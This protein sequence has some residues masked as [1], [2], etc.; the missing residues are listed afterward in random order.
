MFFGCN[1]IE[2]KFS[3]WL[4]FFSFCL[5]FSLALLKRYNELEILKINKILK[6]YKRN[7]SYKRDVKLLKNIGL[8]SGLLSCFILISY[9]QS[10][11][12]S[13]YYNSPNLIILSGIM[14][15]F[16]IVRIWKKAKIVNMN[17]PVEFAL[18]DIFTYFVFLLIVL[19]FIFSKINIF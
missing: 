12:A 17:D 14:L 16:W 15:I 13:E 5:F 11:T 9:S 7:Y 10:L 19:I 2:I 6:N 8:F 4:I 3:S 1:I 18:K